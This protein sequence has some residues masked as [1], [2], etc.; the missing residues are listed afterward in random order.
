MVK[1]S[2][3]LVYKVDEIP[4]TATCFVLAIQHALLIATS[5]IF[6]LILFRVAGFADSDA[7]FFLSMTI[8]VVG[9]GTIIQ[10][11]KQTWIGAGFLCPSFAALFYIVP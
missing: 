2:Y 3:E 11:L 9:I 8:L 5:F 10:S 4:P 6:P 1:P 7:A